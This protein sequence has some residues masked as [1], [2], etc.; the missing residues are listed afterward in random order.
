MVDFKQRYP[1][2]LNAADAGE[3]LFGRWGYR[4]VGAAI[5][6]KSLGLAASH[7]LAGKL[8]IATFDSG[9]NCAIGWAVLIAGVS[10]VLSY[11]R[12]WSGLLGLSVASITCIVIACIITM[13]GA[14]TQDPARL[15]VNNVPV[16]W[17]AFN[18]EVTLADAVGAITNC[19]FAC[20]VL[21][22]I[23]CARQLC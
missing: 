5:V 8:A 1:H 16:H 13:V 12:R 9:T 19:V 6:F 7:I 10:A 4:I 14:G 2:V 17:V 21:C 23:S 22:C 18:T 15:E 3:V 11:N 20:V